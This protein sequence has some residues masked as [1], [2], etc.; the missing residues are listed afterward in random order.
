MAEMSEMGKCEPLGGMAEWGNVQ[1]PD[2]SIAQYSIT[3][4]SIA[5]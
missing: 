5:Q 1:F 4:Y 3:Q 2:P